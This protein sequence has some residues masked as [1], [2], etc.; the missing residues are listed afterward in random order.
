MSDIG[1][2]GVDIG[3]IDKT[4]EEGNSIYFIMADAYAKKK[5]AEQKNMPS[6][7]KAC[8][9]EFDSSFC[10][11]CGKPRFKTNKKKIKYTVSYITD[12]QLLTPRVVNEWGLSLGWFTDDETSDYEPYL[13]KVVGMKVSEF[14]ENTATIF[15]MKQTFIRRFEN[16][17][18]I[19][20]PYDQ[21]KIY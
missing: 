1:M 20:L 5:N 13:F 7:I 3:L 19:K 14:D 8:E 11:E 15:I 12:H 10:P 16:E 4:N 6:K 21:V 17:F 2:V 9:H 18:G